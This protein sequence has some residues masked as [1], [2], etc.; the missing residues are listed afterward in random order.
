MRVRKM[1]LIGLVGAMSLVAGASCGQP[2]AADDTDSTEDTVSIRDTLTSGASE[3]CGA[4]SVAATLTGAGSVRSG[5][6]YN[7]AD[8]FRAYKVDVNN[9]SPGIMG[10]LVAYGSPAPTNADECSRTSLRTYVW[11]RNATGAPTFL[12][13]PIRKG[14]WISDGLGG[15]RCATPSVDLSA[16][17]TP[18]QMPR[19]SN[20]RFAV[21]ASILPPA[22]STTEVYKKVYVS[23]PPGTIDAAGPERILNEMWS[24]SFALVGPAIAPEVQKVWDL[25]NASAGVRGSICR[26]WEVQRTWIRAHALSL[27]KIVAAEHAAAV[28]VRT[29]TADQIYTLICNT[30]TPTA[31]SLP[32]LQAA[33]RDHMM[34]PNTVRAHIVSH[35]GS[36]SF[37]T[38][39]LM[40]QS[41]NLD[42][43]RL[44]T[45]C[46][47]SLS[48]IAEYIALGTRPAGMVGANPLVRN[49][50][51][52]TA[53]IAASAGIG[54][55]TTGDARTKYRACIDKQTAQLTPSC[56]GP[57]SDEPANGDP[58]D[59]PTDFDGPCKQG[60]AWNADSDA[61]VPESQREPGETSAQGETARTKTFVAAVEAYEESTRRAEELAL[62]SKIQASSAAA[63]GLLGAIPALQI[64]ATIVA[65]VGL[66][67]AL[68]NDLLAD[69]ERAKAKEFREVICKMDPGNAEFCGHHN[70]CAEYDL[71][72]D[73]AWPQT[74]PSPFN[75]DGRQT[76]QGERMDDCM[77]Q[78]FDKDYGRLSGFEFGGASPFCPDAHERLVQDCLANPEIIG[79]T[80]QRKPRPECMAVLYPKEVDRK[81]MTIRWCKAKMPNCTGAYLD[82]EGGCAC[83]GG[84]TGI[85]AAG[86]PACPD[87]ANA[88]DCGVDGF[89]DEK[90]CMCVFFDSGLGCAKGG[91]SGYLAKN[92]G[93]V[94]T[95]NFPKQ[96]A[97]RGKN[98]LMFASGNT[99][100]ATRK[101][102]NSAL[103]TS[104]LEVKLSTLLP[105]TT[106]VSGYQG[107]AVQLSCTNEGNNVQNRNLGTKQL[108]ALSAGLNMLTYPLTADDRTACL[109]GGRTPAR[110][111]IRSS[112]PVGQSRLGFED[113]SVTNLIDDLPGLPDPCSPPAPLPGPDPLPVS[114]PPSLT[115]DGL[116]REIDWRFSE[117]T[118][119][120]FPVI[121]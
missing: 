48:E 3:N 63:F 79:P 2:P 106:L 21:R 35:I 5:T 71:R 17:F 98:F 1:H 53:S 52:S 111:E 67:G 43:Q 89:L 73:K 70:R 93:D 42:F 96:T 19:G 85:P 109:N 61:C 55:T 28:D 107:W 12:A 116:F 16:Y 37:E 32:S 11:R 81:S 15:M 90:T 40:A 101:I 49:C 33:M 6:S 95:A 100:V 75:P 59:K 22:G 112:N 80:D 8:C 77:C 36:T 78:L 92:P 108:Q 121:R 62:T 69:R 4:G 41:A 105:T 45:R 99:P 83:P 34:W 30:P 94:F 115:F 91:L 68:T 103:S 86:N 38:G 29:T 24:L 118:L 39:H 110:F 26:S 56:S 60:E 117:G 44:M 65:V 27:K 50:T 51:G 25:R 64:P 66:V 14:A 54:V 97:I 102:Q 57:R 47:G 87:G 18:E 119:V 88:T 72:G 46:G 120:P 76:T 23:I 113:L 10:T 9:Y 74:S 104:M 58:A 114:L 7:P 82:D 20:L 84:G 13:N 31:S